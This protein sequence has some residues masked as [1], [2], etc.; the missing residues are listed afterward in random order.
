MPLG[1]DGAYWL[2]IHVANCFGVDKVSFEERVAWVREHEEQILD[3]ALDPLDGQRFWMDAD[4]PFCALAACFEWLGYSLN[5]RDHVSHLPIALDGSCNGLQ[6]F[7]AMLRDSVGGAATNL[8]PQPKPADIY[9]RVKDVAQEKLRARAESGDPLAIKL[10]GQLTRDIVKQ[11]V[12]TLPYGV[13][14]SGMRAQVLSKFKKLGM[15]DDWETAEYLATLLWECIGEVVIAARAAMDWLRDA[16][17][18]ASSADLPVSW[19]T[20][21]GFPVLQEYRE[22]EGVRIR[23]HVGG[24]E[25]NLVV[26][27][28]GT[29]LDR[30]RQT[31]GISPNFV[32]SCDASHMM[33]TTC[34]AAEN[35]IES[36]A[37]IHDSYGTHAG[38]AAILAAALRQAF[39]DQYS[40]D[41]LADFRQ[42]LVEQLP[43]EAAEKLP[44]LPPH[45]D[46][47][48]S[49]VLESRY[50]FA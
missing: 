15:E 16:S 27:I 48:L 22:E 18:V 12:M 38:Q 26:N 24:R 28:G 25:V 6:N 37:M 3:S 8:I 7:S 13:T 42:Q 17:K 46:L 36:F 49:L 41:V 32:H 35:G 10:D 21:A 45:G 31:L 5:G 20:P 4:S 14:K 50:F 1:E 44:P 34:L 2:A 47:D 30:R 43:P 9:S 19:T 23:P 29:K 11:P 40:G 39:V 33:L